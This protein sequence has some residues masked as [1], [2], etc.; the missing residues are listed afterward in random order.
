MA[1]RKFPQK[2]LFG[3][4]IPSACFIIDCQGLKHN[5]EILDY[6]Q[7]RS[8][9]KILLALKAFAA[10][11]FF[12]LISSA[13]QGPLVG[14]CA[15]SV[16][17]ARLGYEEF[18]GEVH[19]F[20]AAFTEA[21]VLELVPICDHIV[22]NSVR[23]WLR[24]KDLATSYAESLNRKINFGLRINP[25]HSEGAVAIYDPCAASS[26][27]G[28]RLANFDPSVFASGINGLHFHTLCEQGAQ[29]LK[30]TLDAAL[31]KFG[32]YFKK[33]A[34]INFGGGHHITRSDYDLDLLCQEILKWRELFKATIY[35]EPG[36]AVALDA[37][38]LTAEVL[39]IVAADLPVAILDVS[40]AC[41]MPDT[42]EM[43]YDPPLFYQKEDEILEAKPNLGGPHRYWLA[44]KSCLAGDMLRSSYAFERE[45]AIG[46]RLIFGDMAIYSMVKTNTFNGLQLPSIG[47]IS[48]DEFKLRKSFGY[49]DF[50]DRLS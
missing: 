29:E 19:C 31:E 25:E 33:C 16:H 11:A 39:D 45:L 44:G 7:K 6:V 3:S 5:L 24:F 8:G 48:G 2:A 49:T 34:W 10:W 20:A 27:L 38:W 40:P 41:H 17:E 22:F 15:S 30:R 42:L 26:R 9:A 21:E 28:I 1:A 47:S 12:P 46:D 50:R 4:N 43:P 32:P 36:E 37:G 13:Y 18:G 23:Q 35:L 14:T